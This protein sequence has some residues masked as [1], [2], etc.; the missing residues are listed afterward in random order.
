MGKPRFGARCWRSVIAA[1][2]LGLA[3][4]ATAQPAFDRP[5]VR[6]PASAILPAD[7]IRGFHHHAAEEVVNDG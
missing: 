3:L 2:V 1:L 4:E 7:L 5:P 6:F